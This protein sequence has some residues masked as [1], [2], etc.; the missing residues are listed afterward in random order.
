MSIQK[1]LYMVGRDG[2]EPSTIALKE[3]AQL[4]KATLNYS[5]LL[6]YTKFQV[7]LILFEFVLF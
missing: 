6:I 3:L 5:L 2:F 4:I 7:A 1:H